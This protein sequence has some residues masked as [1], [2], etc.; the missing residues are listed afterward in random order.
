MQYI[1][2]NYIVSV[3]WSST[4]GLNNNRKKKSAH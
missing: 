4:A 3:D 2:Y 1:Q